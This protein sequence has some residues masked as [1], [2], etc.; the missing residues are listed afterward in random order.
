MKNKTTSVCLSLFLI[1]IL[2]ISCTKKET[3]KA[4]QVSLRL[5]WLP[6]ATYVGDIVAKDKRF[7][8]NNGLDVSVN[9]GGFELDSIKLV[10]SGSDQFGITGADQLL[11]ARVQG[12]P[13]VAVAAIMQRCPIG[14]ISKKG[15]GI[16]TPYDFVGKKV[17][18]KYGTNAEIIFDALIKKLEIDPTK[19]KRIPVKFD[20]TP[21]LTGQV[22]VLPGFITA[23][24]VMAEKKGVK[25]NI[26][27]PS[28]YGINLYGNVYFT[29]EKMIR[30]KPEIV[31]SFLGAV[32]RAWQ[33][34]IDNREESIDILLNF[35]QKLDKSTELAVLER[36][37]SLFKP[38]GVEEF[39]LGW[40]D[41]KIWEET[42]DLLVSQKVMK[43][44]IDVDSAYT[45]TFLEQVYKD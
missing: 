17:G 3:E 10:A 7:W 4:E 30:E 11:L 21:F 24:S 14:W 45:S 19:I 39:K 44:P 2:L 25:V 9:P 37:I 42:M 23:E 43:Q 31:A 36:T 38:E 32:L 8:Q 18:A 16:T 13:V 33:W 20:I 6:G 27:D 34:V 1:V 22:D 26:I 12:I 28:D 5:K 35:E 15:S 29:T 41:K 40:M